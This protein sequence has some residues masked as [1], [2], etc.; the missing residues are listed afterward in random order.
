M[1][2]YWKHVLQHI[3]FSELC[4]PNVCMFRIRGS[5]Y[6]DVLFLFV[7]FGSETAVPDLSDGTRAAAA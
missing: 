3:F 5:S 4:T 6:P 2:K 7:G 1:F